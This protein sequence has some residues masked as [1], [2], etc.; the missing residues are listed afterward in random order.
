MIL[1]ISFS[2][3][4]KVGREMWEAGKVHVEEL[5]DE[6][7]GGGRRCQRALN[8]ETPQKQPLCERVCVKGFQL[9]SHSA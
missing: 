8:S 7:A 5:L 4:S 6:E 2:A 1:F 3:S 9:I